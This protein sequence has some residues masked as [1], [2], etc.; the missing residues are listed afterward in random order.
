MG[1]H[2]EPDAMG[3]L[4]ES[5]AAVAFF[6]RQRPIEILKGAGFIVAAALMEGMLRATEWLSDWPRSI[7]ILPPMLAAW[8]LLCFVMAFKYR[9]F[10]R[11]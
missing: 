3:L 7:E 8:G 11:G 5:V 4:E 10:L 1:K 9:Q 6:R 2:I